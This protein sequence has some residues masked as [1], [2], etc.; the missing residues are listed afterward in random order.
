VNI[1]ITPIGVSAVAS[2]G[3]TT[4]FLV[5]IDEESILID[6]GSN[7]ARSIYDMGQRVEQLR[8]VYISHV[9]GDH[10]LGLPGLVFTRSVEERASG[11]EFEPLRIVGDSSV[12]SAA[13]EALSLFYPERDFNV[14]FE[15][16]VALEGKSG[17]AIALRTFEVDHAVPSYG[18]V[19][20]IDGVPVLGFT[21]DTLPCEA[22]SRN[23]DGVQIALVE[24]F[25]TDERFGAIARSAK[26][27]T[28]SDAR[29]LAAEIKPV[30]AIPYHMHVPYQQ[31]GVDRDALLRELGRT[32]GVSWMY[33]EV[34]IPIVVAVA[35]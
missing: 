14:S 35:P 24:C 20:S 16:S 22:L 4:S 17:T 6:A 2:S 27:L 30:V 33:P 11:Y 5:R 31:P 34:G 26:H 25:G 1:E 28:A 8:V 18:L 32:D 23:L 3:E 21:S 10:M 13:K 7:S 15:T 9:H 19:I 29:R 12:I